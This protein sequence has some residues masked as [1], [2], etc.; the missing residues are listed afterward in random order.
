M[1]QRLKI[2]H[3]PRTRQPAWP[4]STE[5]HRGPL[6]ARRARHRKL[7]VLL[8]DDVLPESQ[9]AAWGKPYLLAGLLS[10]DR[11]RFGRHVLPFVVDV[12]ISESAL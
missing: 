8:D 1:L 12:C 10:L 9:L 3:S 6:F 7:T 2:E 5:R 4:A 11:P